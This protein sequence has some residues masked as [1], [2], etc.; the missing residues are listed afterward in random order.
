ML[1]TVINRG[2]F[3]GDPVGGPQEELSQEELVFRF[4]DGSL[5]PTI[6]PVVVAQ[7]VI[8]GVYDG[9]TTEKLDDL[10]AETAA[11]AVRGVAEMPRLA[12]AEFPTNSGEHVARKNTGHRTQHQPT[13]Q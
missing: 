2:D 9:V 8:Q 6:S 1:S 13:P 7:K 5:D 10:A 11:T 4:A 3:V 12:S